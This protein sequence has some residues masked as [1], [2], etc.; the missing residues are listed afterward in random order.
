MTSSQEHDDFGRHPKLWT[1]TAVNWVLENPDYSYKILLGSPIKDPAQ[2][3][4]MTSEL[5]SVEAPDLEHAIAVAHQL[6]DKHAH[7]IGEFGL[8]IYLT[9]PQLPHGDQKRLGIRDYKLSA[10]ARKQARS[11]G[12]RGRDLEARV[13]RMVRHAVPFEHKVASRRY[14]GIIMRVED[15]V[16]TWVGLAI[17]PR[18]RRKTGSGR[19]TR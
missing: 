2:E 18:R 7:D 8:E 13:A 11:I 5:E 16:V 3:I 10:E 12:L 6:L 19:K 9:A 14:R 15:D 4:D 1:V 17:P